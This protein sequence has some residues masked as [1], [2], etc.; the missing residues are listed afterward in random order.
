MPSPRHEATL[1]LF[2][3]RPTLA[4][5]VLRDALQIDLP[6]YSDV[7]FDSADLTTVEPA[8]YRADLVVLLLKG[9]PVYG[10]IVEVQLS[11][12]K[13]KRYTWPAYAANLHARLRCPVCLLVVAGNDSLARRL[14]KTVKFGAGCYFTPL[15]LGPSGVPKITDEVQAGA[16]PELAV[17]SAMAHGRDADVR[18]AVRIAHAACAGVATLDEARSA[19]YVD[20][21]LHSLGVAAREALQAMDIKNYQYQSAFARKYHSRG[22]AEG[23]KEGREEGIAHGVREGRAGLVTRLLEK[24]FGALTPQARQRV[25]SATIAD[26]DSIGERLLTA[27][28]LD[29]AVEIQTNSAPE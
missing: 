9:K 6:E 12:D 17:L 7:S 1:L 21:I 20:L 25:E 15:V 13:D 19:L 23:K 26:L 27:N 24:R 2:R 22:I 8:E 10:I 5:D 28:T 11:L 4:P 16:D 14:A 3:N 18:T 29:D